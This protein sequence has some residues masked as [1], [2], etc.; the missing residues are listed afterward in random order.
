MC[1]VKYLSTY[2]PFTT[3]YQFSLAWRI[4]TF[5]VVLVCWLGVLIYLKMPLFFLHLWK[6]QD[7]GLTG[8]LFYFC[9][10]MQH[11]KMS[12][13][14]LLTAVVS[15]KKL[16]ISHIVV[17]PYA[18]CSFSLPAFMIFSLY[19]FS[20]S[21]TLI[22][23]SVVFFVFILFGIHWASWIYTLCFSKYWGNFSHYFFKY[24]STLFSLLWLH[25]FRYFDIVSQ[26]TMALLFSPLS[27]L[28][29][30]FRKDNFCWLFLRVHWPFLLLISKLLLNP[31]SKFFISDTILSDLEFPFVYLL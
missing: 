7:L 14:C 5:F 1:I 29:L 12:F 28:S 30:F 2:L 21:L 27:V 9:F 15:D 19:L 4:L 26:V 16:A 3:W 6:M 10:L 24:F 11:L 8:C 22:F 17:P 20:S 31:S 13:H 18:M 25:I 23:L